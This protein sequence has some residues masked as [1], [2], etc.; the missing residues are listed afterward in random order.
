MKEFCWASYLFETFV[1]ILVRSEMRRPRN[2]YMLGENGLAIS[3]V[4]PLRSNYDCSV[5]RC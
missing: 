4:S 2:S 5:A 1:S 3:R